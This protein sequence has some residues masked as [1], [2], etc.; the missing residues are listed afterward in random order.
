MRFPAGVRGAGGGDYL[1]DAVIDTSSEEYRHACEVRRVANMPSGQRRH[2][3]ILGVRKR[4]G[5]KAADRLYWD[6]GKLLESKM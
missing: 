5:N 3:Y 4:R 1:G 2:E 6:V